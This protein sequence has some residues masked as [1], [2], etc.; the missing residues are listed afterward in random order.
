MGTIRFNKGRGWW[1]VDYTAADGTRV[2]QRIGAGEEGKRLAKQVLKQREA[3]AQLGIQNIPASRTIRF[4]AFAEDWLRRAAGRNLAP[5]TFE[6]YEGAIRNYLVPAFGGKHLG[7]IARRDV[8]LFLAEAKTVRRN[9]SP[10]SPKTA[11]HLLTLLKAVLADAVEHG[12][13]ARSPAASVRP[14]R[15]TDQVDE[16]HALSPEEVARLLD[17][18][19]EPWRTFYLLAA[20][21]GLRRGEL[22]GLRWGDVDLANGKL[23]SAAACTGSGTATVTSSARR[24]SSP[25]THAAA[26]TSPPARWMRSAYIPPATGRTTTSSAPGQV[27]RSAPTPSTPPSGAT[28]PWRGCRRSAFTTCGIRTPHC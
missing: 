16:M 12:H 13:L 20:S 15:R 18:A 25:A 2:R 5:K 22:L 7:A 23:Q 11:A 17:A 1:Y 24:R 8:E 10:V 21:T 19:E 26:W 4:A 14:P 27:G 3:E 6:S 9:P 28:S